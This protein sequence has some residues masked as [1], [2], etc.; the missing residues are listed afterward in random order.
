MQDLEDCNICICMV[1]TVHSCLCILSVHV[2]SHTIYKLRYE[3]KGFKVQTI[4]TSKNSMQ[5]FSQFSQIPL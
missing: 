4:S 2:Y 1:V 3:V 5:E